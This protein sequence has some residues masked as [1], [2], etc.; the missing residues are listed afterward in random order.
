MKARR[1]QWWDPRTWLAFMFWE[2]RTIFAA[3]RDDGWSDW[4]AAVVITVVEILG[5]GALT[6]AVSVYLGRSLIDRSNP[7][8]YIFPLVVAL[9][10]TKAAL[11][12]NKRCR[13]ST[14]FES[15]SAPIRIGGGWT[16]V[17]LVLLTIIAA[18]HF[19]VAQRLLPRVIH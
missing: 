5:V 3:I 11:G 16:V 15:Y 8:L 1:A 14:E 9:L 10:N 18:G 7:Y 6:D 13:L 19:A 2:L 12:K 17:L 4:K